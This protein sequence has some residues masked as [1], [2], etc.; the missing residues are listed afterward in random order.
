MAGDHW[1][2]LLGVGKWGTYMSFFVLIIGF[3]ISVIMLNKAP[4]ASD[5]AKDAWD[6]NC[7][8]DFEDQC[9]ANS[10]VYRVSFALTIIFIIQMLG[11]WLVTQFYDKLWYWKIVIFASFVVG[12]FFANAEVFDLH[13]Y[14]WFARITAF[15]FLII[16]QAILIDMAYTW[17]EK[18]TAYAVEEGEEKGKKWL[19]GLV[20]ISSILFAGSLTVIGLL[21]WQF[22]G[23][24]DNAA[25]ISLTLIFSMIVTVIQLFL[26]DEGSI[27]TSAMITAYAVY[28]CYSAV[29]LNPVTSCNPTLDSGYQ[30]LSTVIGLTL[31]LISLI[32]TTHSTVMMVPGSTDSTTGEALNFTNLTETGEQNRARKAQEKADEERA[33]ET[34]TEPGN[35]L[36]GGGSNGTSAEGRAARYERDGVSALFI[37]VSFVFVLI[38]GYYCMILTNWATLQNKEKMADPRTGKAAMWIQVSGQWIAF[39]LYLWSLMAPKLFPNREF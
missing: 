6:T 15:L 4:D 36:A 32:W 11:T 7:P 18:W 21:Y 26:T 19:I 10:A 28:V 31:T 23:C 22:D 38:S 25:I 14:A 13:G 9:I 37:Q 35:A 20:L 5:A 12:F 1:D 24:S 8:S 2:F 33:A 39:V 17:N 3:I 27:L 34:G 16:Q 29:T 30:T